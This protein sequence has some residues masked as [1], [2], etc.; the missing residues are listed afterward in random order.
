MSSAFKESE[1]S[2]VIRTISVLIIPAIF[3]VVTGVGFI[4]LNWM[5]G[6]VL[7]NIT[8]TFYILGAIVLTNITGSVPPQSI[9]YPIVLLVLL[10]TRY[11]NSFLIKEKAS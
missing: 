6:Y 10:N 9:I 4:K 5:Y 8:S 7:S 1:S 11:K 3:S 2:A